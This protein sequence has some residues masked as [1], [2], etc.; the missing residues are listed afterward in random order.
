MNI[1]LHVPKNNIIKLFTQNKTTLITNHT[2]YASFNDEDV[3]LIE[4]VSEISKT[5]LEEWLTLSS[6]FEESRLVDVENVIDKT[7]L[8]YDP[9]SKAIKVCD[10]KKGI[11]SINM[12][13]E[14]IESLEGTLFGYIES[15]ILMTKNQFF[16][17]LS[18]KYV[19]VPKN[20][21][22]KQLKGKKYLHTINDGTVLIEDIDIEGNPLKLSGKYHFVSVDSIGEAKIEASNFIKILLNKKKIE[23]V[24]EEYV[25]IN[26]HK[27]K[28]NSSVNN[29][30]PV[31]SVDDFF[32]KDENA[33]YID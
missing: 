5:Q 11:Y 29:T 8:L 3:M 27:F 21:P 33:I 18:G 10:Q 30:I 26:K 23:Y 25:Q 9:E 31:G 16:E 32:E 2:K 24:D 19:P 6:W 7:I 15:A 17:W 13:K 4:S 22:E 12:D 20:K 1:V 28:K 14:S